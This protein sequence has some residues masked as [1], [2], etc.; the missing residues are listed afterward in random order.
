MAVV[1]GTSAA[2]MSRT[3]NGERPVDPDSAEG[4]H[5]LLFLRVFRSLDTLVG[6]DEV[7][8]RSWLAARNAHLAGQSPR[9]LL[10]ST[11]GLVRVAEY[12]DAMRG[13][14]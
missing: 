3:W 13:T 10:A 2:S 12:L 1:L 6:G 4:R 5:A 9:A 8:A 7:K 11:A 14:L